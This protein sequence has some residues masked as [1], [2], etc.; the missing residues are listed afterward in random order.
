MGAGWCSIAWA[1]NSLNLGIDRVYHPRMERDVR[2][3]KSNGI[4][5]D[6]Y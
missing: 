1:R 6:E 3:K 4:K 5:P 2:A